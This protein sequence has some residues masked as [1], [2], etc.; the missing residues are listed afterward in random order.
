[1]PALSETEIRA[2]KA[3]SAPVT[4][5]FRNTPAS[6]GL[7]MLSEHA[8]VNIRWAS[9]V[10]A[11]FASD[12]AVELSMFTLNGEF[13]DVPLRSVLAHMLVVDG[14]IVPLIASAGPGCIVL[15]CQELPSAELVTRVYAM[16]DLI[17]DEKDSQ[18]IIKLIT[19]STGSYW[20]CEESA[21]V[22]SMLRNGRKFPIGDGDADL[23]MSI[24]GSITYLESIQGL[25]VK[26]DG[27]TH[28][29]ISDLVR[30]I[31]QAQQLN[32]KLDARSAIRPAATAS[33]YPVSPPSP[34]R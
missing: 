3:L 21:G 12:D 26:A 14:D 11:Q 32:E 2:E 17:R 25:V 10:A 34:Y 16:G 1:V 33:P 28:R 9:N 24:A 19:S 30:L 13:H 4:V 6:E 15:S 18:Q 29:E 27:A 22:Q 23:L 5:A 7:R 8:G 31:R 20:K